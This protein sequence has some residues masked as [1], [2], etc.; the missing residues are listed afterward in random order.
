M[1]PSFVRGHVQVG[2]IKSSILL[3]KRA[4]RE[5]SAPLA[6]KIDDSKK[7]TMYQLYLISMPN[8]PHSKI[9]SWGS[10]GAGYV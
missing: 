2:P 7:C 4:P 1:H 9:V 6:Y 3:G 8:R 10:A 5:I